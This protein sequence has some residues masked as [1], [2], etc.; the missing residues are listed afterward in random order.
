MALIK[1]PECGKEV[2]DRADACPVCGF[3][4]SKEQEKGKIKIKLGMFS[5]I[6][7]NQSVTITANGDTLWSG[8]SGEV[9]EFELTKILSIDIKYSMNAAHYGGSCTA[10]I[11]P[12]KGNKYA[13]SVRQGLL[14]TV[15]TFQ[16][17][18]MID[19]D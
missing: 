2:S 19:S 11:D 15:L 16:A 14:K 7:G 13:V 6:G 4:I 3:P 17:V 5:G 12:S 1:C 9:A 8:K 18:D 10:T